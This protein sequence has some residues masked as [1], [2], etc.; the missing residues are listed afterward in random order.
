[1]TDDFSPV[2]SDYE[3]SFPRYS[4]T[5]CDPYILEFSILKRLSYWREIF[6]ILR[7]LSADLFSFDRK[8]NHHGGERME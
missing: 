8:I 6:L 3:P 5:L 2:C 4:V 1:M 7:L